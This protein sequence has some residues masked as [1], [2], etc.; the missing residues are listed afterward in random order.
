MAPPGRAIATESD[1]V[2]AA[3]AF[4]DRVDAAARGQLHDPFNALRAAFSDDI[5]GTELATERD[6]IR[7]ATDKDDPLRSEPLGCNHGAKSHGA[8]SDHGSRLAWP[9]ACHPCRV[10][11]GPHHVGKAQQ[12]WHECVVCFRRQCIEGAVRLRDAQCFGLGAVH[13]SIAKE[14]AVHAGGLQAFMTELAL[15][16][17]ESKRHDHEVAR[18]QFAYFT[19]DRLHDTDGFV[20]HALARISALHQAIGPQIAAADACARYPHDCI[21]GL[22]DRCVRNILDPDI[23]GFIHHRCAHE[24]LR[25]SEFRIFDVRD[26]SAAVLWPNGKPL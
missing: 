24:S 13:A 5:G 1:G 10:V 6:T 16:I 14:S 4:E 9:N 8:V 21:R 23:P 2:F 20:P 12:R 25:C 17:R 3:D 19:A 11:A 22:D 18:L 26:V 15:P 7:V